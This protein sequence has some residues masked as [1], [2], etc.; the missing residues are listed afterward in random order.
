MD[1]KNRIKNDFKQI[2]YIIP[3]I[4][5]YQFDEKGRLYMLKQAFKTYRMIKP[6]TSKGVKSVGADTK[7]L[8]S[9]IQIEL[10]SKSRFVYFLDVNK[11]IAVSGNI[12][13]NF[14][15]AYDKVIHGTFESLFEQSSGKDCYGSEAKYVADGIEILKNRIVNEL[16][17]SEHPNK[18]RLIEYFNRIL[19][20]PAEHFDEALQ[21][22]LFF[23][24]I[25]WQT[26]HRLNGLGRLDYILTDLYERDIQ[27]SLITEEEAHVIVRDFLENLNNYRTYK[28]DALEGDI[29]QIIVL[30]D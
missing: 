29:G 14:T 1:L 7:A 26:R 11:T 4:K 30:G 21:R 23:N 25:L 3:F 28:S 27:N 16:M 8:L 15:L 13:S 6:V 20:C 5:K 2:N 24:Q 17:I 19:V 12:L 9:T 22:I 18:N 10:N